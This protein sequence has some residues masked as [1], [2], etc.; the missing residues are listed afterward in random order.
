MTQN[1]KSPW[2]ALQALHPND[3]TPSDL[4]HLQKSSDIIW[5]I[6][7]AWVSTND[8]PNLHFFVSL[9]IENTITLQL[10]KRALDKAGV[11]IT[12]DGW[13]FATTSDAGQALLGM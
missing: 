10:M 1:R 3:Y 5:F 9:S 13:G 11:D 6:Y 7:Q 4:P 2:E 12:R 8:L